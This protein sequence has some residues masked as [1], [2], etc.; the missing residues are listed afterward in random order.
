MAITNGFSKFRDLR[1]LVHDIG[2]FTSVCV[3]GVLL[4]NKP[5]A[6]L[7]LFLGAGTNKVSY[8]GMSACSID[9]EMAAA[10]GRID[11]TF[12]PVVLF[13]GVGPW[14]YFSEAAE[15]GAVQ[16]HIVE[17]ASLMAGYFAS[18]EGIPFHPVTAIRGSDV[19]DVNP[20][21]EYIDDERFGRVPIVRQMAPDVALIHA[22]Q[23][24]HLG[25]ARLLGSTAQSELLLA[26]ASK[27]VIV[28]ADEI[29]P[30]EDFAAHPRDTTIPSMYVN[31]V[32]H[33]PRG[34]WPTSSPTQYDADVPFLKDYWQRA[35]AARRGRDL[36]E[37]DRLIASVRTKIHD[38][39]ELERN[40]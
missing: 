11:Q 36:D 39:L 32:C 26:R 5:M 13:D 23:A 12:V 19:T 16:A 3:G 29:V 38:V 9:I 27:F 20:L 14:P 8:S 35:T 24:D 4:D 31:A 10:S 18:A 2:Q 30:T 7:E 34:A 22:Q 28:S 33:I 37:M 1:D 21:V 15:S 6:L 40:V 25:N 17:V